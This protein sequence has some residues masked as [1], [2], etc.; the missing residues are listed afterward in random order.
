MDLFPCKGRF[1]RLSPTGRSA[2]EGVVIDIEIRNALFGMDLGM[3]PL[4]ALGVDGYY[5]KFYQLH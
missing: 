2:L 4:K 1:S 3:D 5:A